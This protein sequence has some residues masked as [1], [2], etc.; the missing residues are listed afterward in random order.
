MSRS[1]FTDRF[2]AAPAF[3]N[4]TPGRVN[5]I[6]EHTDY[7][8]GLVLPTALVLGIDI[9]LSPRIDNKINIVSSSFDGFCQRQIT[10]PLQDHWSDY[11]LGAM[12]YANIENIFSGGAN[13]AIKSTLPEGAGL[14]SSAALLVGIIKLC[15]EQS[16][17]T[18][19][20][21]KIAKLAQ[22]IEN[23]FIGV[24]C[25]IMDQMAVALA[26]PGQALKLNTQTLEYS[27]LSLPASHVMVVIH[28][29]VYR[30]LKEGRYK[31]RKEEC[32]EIKAELGRDGICL[33]DPSDLEALKDMP[34]HIQRRARH[35]MTEHRRTKRAAAALR[36]NDMVTFGKLMTESH[37]S[38]RDDFEITLPSIDQIVESAVALGALGARMTGGGFGG[39]VVACVNADQTASWTRSLLERHPEAFSVG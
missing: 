7:N 21:I 2:G 37:N 5:L 22:K 29:G 32:D 15:V 6:G 36:E 26:R 17:Q 28:S 38:M 25:G 33:I 9:S 35:C 8:G 3:N 13:I 23:E 18:M 4:F 39:C 16:G 20:A 12:K 14:S 11:V 30:Q 31:V 1:L 19:N 10:D 34:D 27:I 24:P